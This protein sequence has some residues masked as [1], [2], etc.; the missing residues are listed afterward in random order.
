VGADDDP[1]LRET[2][3]VALMRLRLPAEA[4]LDAGDT[5][6]EAATPWQDGG[7]IGVG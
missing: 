1:L 3:R 4:D 6:A 2:V 7:Q 5:R